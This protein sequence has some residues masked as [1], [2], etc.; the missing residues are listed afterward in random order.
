MAKSTSL[1]SGSSTNKDAMRA[2]GRDPVSRG[3][4]IAAARA[5]VAV[6]TKI[7]KKDTDPAIL[8]LAK[9]AR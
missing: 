1:R 8:R 4:A 5:I 3:E 9:S 6:N 7:L 2:S